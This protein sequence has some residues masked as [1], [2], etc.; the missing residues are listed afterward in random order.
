MI[1][2]LSLAGCAETEYSWVVKISGEEISPRRYVAAQMHS[3]VEA[4]NMADYSDDILDGNVDGVDTARWIDEHTI[5]WLKR[6]SY[7]EKEFENRNLKFGEDADEF[8]RIFA[9]EGWDSVSRMYKNNDLDIQYYMDYLKLLYKEQL[10][11]NS[12][13]VYDDANRVTDAEIEEYLNKNISR[14][15]FFPVARIND[16]GSELTE[17]QDVALDDISSFEFFICK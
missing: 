15:S 7:I 11:F 14:V 12:I 6:I 16:D 1:L 3:Y 5:H 4:R 17:S 8:I 2:M 10:V 9:E 13:F